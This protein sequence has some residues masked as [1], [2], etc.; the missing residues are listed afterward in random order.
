MHNTDNN[1]TAISDRDQTNI[2]DNNVR[3]TRFIY[4]SNV[5]H[6]CVESL[7]A[8]QSTWDWANGKKLQKNGKKFFHSRVFVPS[9][10]AV[11]ISKSGKCYVKQNVKPVGVTSPDVNRMTASG[12]TANTSS[13]NEGY[14]KPNVNPG[15]VNV[16]RTNV[17]T[18]PASDAYVKQSLSANVLHD[19]E[20]ITCAEV[21]LQGCNGGI[22]VA[23][24][25]EA[26][27]NHGNRVRS[28]PDVSIRQL[29]SYH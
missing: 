1:V 25:G 23:S 17:K 18:L 20:N 11:C 28:A 26:V 19:K 13:L 15:E 24:D 27:A 6:K 16:S 7:M 22:V 10:S 9:S 3:K 4:N 21:S 5:N 14:V 12:S 29:G 8:R 2:I